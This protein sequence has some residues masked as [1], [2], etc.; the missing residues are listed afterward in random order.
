MKKFW[1]WKTSMKIMY[2]QGSCI[3]LCLTIVILSFIFHLDVF[4]YLLN[5]FFF[6]FFFAIFFPGAHLW[7]KLL[8]MLRK[9][10]EK[11]FSGPI[12]SLE[13]LSVL[14]ELFMYLLVPAESDR[15]IFSAKL[16]FHPVSSM[17]M[18]VKFKWCFL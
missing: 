14:A 16:T 13:V 18:I 17:Q 11:V 4:L 2:S 6:F 10:H 3:G 7:L 9:I 1:N 12:I 15:T 5:F 8:I